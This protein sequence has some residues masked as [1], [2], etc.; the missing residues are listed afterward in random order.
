M[1][2]AV[3]PGGRPVQIAASYRQ[4][5]GAPA[6]GLADPHDP[7]DPATG[8]LP[9]LGD[10]PASLCASAAPACA[11]PAG[12]EP[13]AAFDPPAGRHQVGGPSGV[14]S[15]SRERLPGTVKAP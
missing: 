4:E 6:P 11:H 1:R 9:A 13:D 12:A 10:A 2:S 5:A 7:R 3:A 8:G 14:P 15:E